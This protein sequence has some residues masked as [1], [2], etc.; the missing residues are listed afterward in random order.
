MAGSPNLGLPY[1]AASQAQKHVTVNEA[2][3]LL[4]AVTQ[5]S[6]KS[7][8]LNAAPVSPAEGDRYIVGAAPT[9]AWAGRALDI[10]FFEGGAWSFLDPREGFLAWSD[11]DDSV[12][13]YTGGAWLRF[14]DVLALTASGGMCGIGAFEQEVTVAGAFTDTTAFFPDRSIMLCVG[15]RTTLAVTGATSFNCGI[16]GDTSKFGGSLG[17]TLGSTNTGVIG[18]TAVYANTP[19]RLTAVGANFTGGKVRVVGYYLKFTAPAS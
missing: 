3:R 16:A 11:A 6:V 2:L 18:P 4:D 14:G 19:V 12:F 17:V 15:V 9:G 1:L 7:R 10:A 13:V 5:L 8:G